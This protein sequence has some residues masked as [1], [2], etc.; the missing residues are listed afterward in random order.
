M[1]DPQ[2]QVSCHCHSGTIEY[3]T[4]TDAL[5]SSSLIGK[6]HHLHQAEPQPQTGHHCC[7]SALGPLWLAHTAVGAPPSVCEHIS[8][9][10]APQHSF[11]RLCMAEVRQSLRHMLS[12]CFYWCEWGGGG[13]SE[14]FEFWI[15]QVCL[16]CCHGMVA[17]APPQ[18]SICF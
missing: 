14:L 12:M 18:Q 7:Q 8:W 15:T 1:P 13:R 11:T 17:F 2:P 6:S 10:P 3:I 9:P 5:H 4:G 16:L